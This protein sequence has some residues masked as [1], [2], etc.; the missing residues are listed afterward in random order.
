MIN[1]FFDFE[2]PYLEGYFDDDYDIEY[3]TELC[4]KWLPVHAW[5]HGMDALKPAEEIVSLDVMRKR[6]R[7]YIETKNRRE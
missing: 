2:R 1:G 4:T 5:T 6:L 3:I 7:K